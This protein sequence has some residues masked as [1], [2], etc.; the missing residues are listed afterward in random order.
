MSPEEVHTI[1]HDRTNNMNNYIVYPDAKEVL[2]SLSQS[3]KLGIISD[4][5]PSIEKQLCTIGV[6]DYFSTTTYSF[7]LGKFKP[8]EILYKDAFHCFLFRDK[9]IAAP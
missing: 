2:E 9:I 8:D 1:A 3:Y 5:W 4:T 7:A 6:R